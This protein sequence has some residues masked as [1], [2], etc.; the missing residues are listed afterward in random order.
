[1]T[2]ALERTEDRWRC[3][4]ELTENCTV[5]VQAVGFDGR[6]YEKSQYIR[7]FPTGSV[8]AS[9]AEPDAGASGSAAPSV[10][11]GGQGTVI[12]SASGAAAESGREFFTISTP[13]EHVFY[14]VIDRN[15]GSENVYF[16]N[17][18]TESDLL[19]LAEEDAG[20]G[21]G[22]SA[23]PEPEPVCACEDKCVPG[24]VE[25][26]CPVCMLAWKDCAGTAPVH[27]DADTPPEQA[28]QNGSGAMALVVFAV[29]AAGGA[30]FYLKIYKPRKE[31][32]EAEDLDELTGGPEETV[33]EDEEEPAP[34][35]PCGEPEEPD[36]PEGYHYE[37]DGGE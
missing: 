36:F 5:E 29:L 9:G 34:R 15:R 35:Y 1:M 22:V 32:A 26:A 10:P 25:A 2:G 28:E 4:V 8:S 20:Q 16:L 27:T 12:D 13:D 23:V 33:N 7:C 17:A 31:L 18:V 30:G 6:T 37:E 14:L 19:A 11:P 24:A 21:G 3:V